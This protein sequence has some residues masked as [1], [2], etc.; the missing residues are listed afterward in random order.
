MTS[1]VAKFVQKIPVFNRC[2]VPDSQ[3]MAFLEPWRQSLGWSVRGVV[4][5]ID[6][7]VRVEVLCLAKRCAKCKICLRRTEVCL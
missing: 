6:A 1:Q 2:H 7:L 5:L 4:D 3:I